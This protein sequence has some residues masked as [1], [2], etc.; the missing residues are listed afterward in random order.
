MRWVL[1]LWMS[2]ILAVGLVGGIP[3]VSQE[4][5]P[6]RVTEGAICLDVVDRKCVGLNRTFS[7]KV[8]RIYCLTRIEGAAG[9]TE[10]VHAWYFRDQERARVRLAVRSSN[11]R[12]YSSKKIQSYEIG[13]WRVEILGSAGKVLKVIDFQVVP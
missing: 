4:P 2:L 11:W 10:I 12:T 3:A 9:P 7:S 13:P 1:F 6:L 8:G 5:N